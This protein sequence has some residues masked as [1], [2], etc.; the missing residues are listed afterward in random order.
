MTNTDGADP[1]LRDTVALFEATEQTGTTDDCM[2]SPFYNDTSTSRIAAF[3]ELRGRV[4]G[5]QLAERVLGVS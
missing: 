4:P 5:T 3:A 2:S 1:A